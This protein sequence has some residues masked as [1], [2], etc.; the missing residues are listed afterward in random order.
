[1][2]DIAKRTLSLAIYSMIINRC[3]L[4]DRIERVSSEV[5]NEEHLSE[6]VLDIDQALGDLAHFYEL[7]CS[8]EGGGY[9]YDKIVANAEE[10]YKQDCKERENL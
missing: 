8:V 9:G 4:L 3:R 7:A 10:D 6:T 1:M 5:E 2:S